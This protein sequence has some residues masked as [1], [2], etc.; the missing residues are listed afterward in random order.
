MTLVM[1]YLRGKGEEERERKRERER[2]RNELLFFLG[3]FENTSL[4]V[5]SDNCKA[6]LIIIMYIKLQQTII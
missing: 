4:T 3:M 2:E 6:S 5:L 1:D